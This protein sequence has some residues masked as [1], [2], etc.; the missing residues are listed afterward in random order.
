M[1]SEKIIAVVTAAHFAQTRWV[2]DS[3]KEQ[4]GKSG[5]HCQS[6]LGH[7]GLGLLGAAGQE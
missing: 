5:G 4:K 1:C 6:C 7:P 3:D 2:Q